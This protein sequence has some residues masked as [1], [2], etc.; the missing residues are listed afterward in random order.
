MPFLQNHVARACLALTC[1]LT[2]HPA[3]VSASPEPSD[4]LLAR[5]AEEFKAGRYAE[6]MATARQARAGGGGPAAM[7]TLAV[8]ALRL[9]LAPV[10]WTAYE[11]IA[12]DTTASPTLARRAR[13]QL[14]ALGSQTALVV[15]ETEQTGVEVLLGSHSLGHTPLAPLRVF[16]PVASLAARFPDGR[17]E[18]TEL[19]VQRGRRVSWRLQS[20]PAATPPS[21]TAPPSITPEPPAPS[22]V[23]EAD[24]PPLVVWVYGAEPTLVAQTAE[25]TGRILG[26]GGTAER[27][28]VQTADLR[29]RAA[30]PDGADSPLARLAARGTAEALENR[31]LGLFG[32]ASGPATT[33]ERLCILLRTERDP[34]LAT[35]VRPAKVVARFPPSAARRDASGPTFE[36]WL[37]S[38]VA[39]T[40]LVLAD[41]GVRLEGPGRA[42]LPVEPGAAVGATVF[43]WERLPT[44]REVTPAAA[45]DI[46][47]EYDGCE[48]PVVRRVDF[49]ASR[50]IEP[51]CEGETE[52]TITVQ[53]DHEGT[54]EAR[55]TDPM[56]P[57]LQR[58]AGLQNGE[59][60]ALVLDRTRA[61]Q[62]ECRFRSG[63]TWRRRLAAQ[64]IIR[65][66]G[67]RCE[68]FEAAHV[69]TV[70][71][72][73][74][75]TRLRLDGAWIRP[76][77]AALS[78]PTP[79]TDAPSD[80]LEPGRTY[81]FVAR[82]GLHSLHAF[83]PGARTS[84]AAPF[85]VDDARPP[86]PLTA[87][88]EDASPAELVGVAPGPRL[89][90]GAAS[91][92]PAPRWTRLGAVASGAL[93]LAG[94]ALWYVGEQRGSS[95][96]ELEAQGSLHPADAEAARLEAGRL[97]NGGIGLTAAAGLAL[98]GFVTAA[99]VLAED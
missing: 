40:S 93:L 70:R 24:A 65:P 86:E 53:S 58:T 98:T 44:T 85:A 69:Q 66:L 19:A 4:A 87:S 8:A 89:D 75:G 50:V 28:R 34:L 47:F 10:A 71:T 25:L 99:I 29:D 32:A 11:A 45:Y 76:F 30:R 56:G 13:N 84:W 49:G 74:G 31:C 64:E 18:R 21:P 79:G 7:E 72:T 95:A 33:P 3:A 90:A 60:T 14:G 62:V 61:W 63:L 88:F 67:L 55:T 6:S 36:D 94:G 15:V 59:R 17:V 96:T 37:W 73:H 46:T 12:A 2:A 80:T 83:A 42:L 91:P 41:G 48:R 92:A 97:R 51:A 77:A 81:W 22:A 57:P 27:C 1:L 39:R 9:G 23:E 16:P 54:V 38:T 5:A 52:V 82:P 68:R 35:F 43:R 20:P 26:C 78:A